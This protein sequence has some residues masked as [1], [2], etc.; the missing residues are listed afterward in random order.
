MGLH[1]TWHFSTVQCTHHYR[2]F[3]FNWHLNCIH[4]FL[5]RW[6]FNLFQCLYFTWHFKRYSG[7]EVF[8]FQPQQ[9]KLLYLNITFTTRFTSA[10]CGAYSLADTL[11]DIAIHHFI[12][13]NGHSVLSE[14][15]LISPIIRMT[16]QLLPELLIQLILQ[17]HSV[18]IPKLTVQLL[19]ALHFEWQYLNFLQFLY[20]DCHFNF[21]SLFHM[22]QQGIFSSKHVH[23]LQKIKPF[24]SYLKVLFYLKSAQTL[25]TQ[26]LYYYF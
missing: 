7:S 18:L 8:A 20:F 3:H 17:L 19:S 12:H 23:F 1:T 25:A 2:S 9:N 22:F 13:L 5:F 6:H 16:F 4:L 10:G 14:L 21:N 11:T 26:I 15:Q 24:N